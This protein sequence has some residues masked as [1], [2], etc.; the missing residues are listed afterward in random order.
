MIYTISQQSAKKAEE[1]G[2]EFE[3][4]G[5][6]DTYELAAAGARLAMKELNR[7]FYFVQSWEAKKLKKEYTLRRSMYAGDGTIESETREMAHFAARYERKRAYIDR[8]RAER[9]AEGAKDEP[10]D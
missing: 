3:P 2:R 5:F 1:Q 6:F 8:K 10:R 4:S 7:T 9:A